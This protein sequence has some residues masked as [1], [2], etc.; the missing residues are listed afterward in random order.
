M[1]IVAPPAAAPA[2]PAPD[3]ERRVRA[4]GRRSRPARRRPAGAARGR[5]KTG[6]WSCS[7]AIPRCG[8][9]SSASL[10]SRPRAPT[11]A[12]WPPT[13]L[14]SSARRSG[15]RSAPRGSGAARVSR[16]GAATVGAAIPRRGRGPGRAAAR[17]RRDRG[18]AVHRMATRFI[19]GPTRRTPCPARSPVGGRRGRVGGPARRGDRHRR[20][21]R[22]LRAALRRGA[23][24]AGAGGPPVARPAARSTSL[25]RVNL[26]VKVTA[27]TA[28][29]KAEAPEFGHRG[30]HAPAPDPPAHG[31]A[32]RRAPARRHGVDG[33]AR[34]DHRTRH[35]APQRAGVP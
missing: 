5:S 6:A 21:G 1:T 24:D 25:P 7:R 15:Q 9:R 33:L 35:R 10:T 13:S 31:E 29:V 16:L 19:V 34:P 20:R 30:R 23:A 17:R 12:T 4:L 26:S 22:P 2:S 11:G 27:L 8:P 18:L 32:G 28:Q 3:I 14:L